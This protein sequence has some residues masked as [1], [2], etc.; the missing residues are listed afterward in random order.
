MGD[1]M[2]SLVTLGR[3][4]DNVY[5]DNAIGVYNWRRSNVVSPHKDKKSGFFGALYWRSTT[6]SAIVAFRGTEFSKDIKD[7]AADTAILAN[8]MPMSQ[9]AQAFNYTKKCNDFVRGQG[10][11]EFIIVGHRLG[12]GLAAVVAANFGGCVG[13]TFNAPGMRSLQGAKFG[14]GNA[15]RVVNV[16]ASADLVSKKG[17]HVGCE[18][19]SVFVSTNP[20]TAHKM[21][22]LWGKLATHPVGRKTPQELLS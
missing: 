8:Q 4:A 1:F 12:G 3:V 10:A 9:I 7:I 17:K 6:R 13:V 20:G 19:L 16:R 21:T 2:V 22:E 18:P 14:W 11:V 5:E 15:P